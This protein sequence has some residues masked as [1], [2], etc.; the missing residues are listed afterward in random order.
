M[1]CAVMS[2]SF[3][4]GY[5]RPYKNDPFIRALLNQSIDGVDVHVTILVLECLPVSVLRG[6]SSFGGLGYVCVV[7]CDERYFALDETNGKQY[8]LFEPKNDF[9]GYHL[10][11]YFSHENI[12][13]DSEIQF[14]FIEHGGMLL[15]QIPHYKAFYWID[16]HY[17]EVMA[18]VPMKCAELEMFQ[19]E[20]YGTF[21]RRKDGWHSKNLQLLAFAQHSVKN[22]AVFHFHVSEVARSPQPIDDYTTSVLSYVP[23]DK[24]V[25]IQ[26]VNGEGFISKAQL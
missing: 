21:V 26:I 18:A 14:A 19:L 15:S 3:G 9:I 2:W 4:L 13:S 24:F 23:L 6:S 11:K 10:N 8:F 17:E 16:A 20:P 22:F 25:G 1:K 12:S 5:F 7:S